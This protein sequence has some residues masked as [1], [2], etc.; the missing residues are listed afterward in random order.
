MKLSP[1]P[2]YL[3]PLRP[4]YSPQHPLLK[5]PQ[6]T[7]TQAVAMKIRRLTTFHLL[8]LNRVQDTCQAMTEIGLFFIMRDGE[9][10]G[11][12]N[13]DTKLKYGI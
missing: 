13:S 8:V 10:N 1:L 4:K 12:R 2:C 3:A 6:L 9:Q 11:G 7:R 5:H